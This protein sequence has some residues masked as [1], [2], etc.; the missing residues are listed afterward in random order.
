MYLNCMYAYSQKWFRNIFLKYAISH[1]LQ[2][3]K[4]ILIMM[5]EVFRVIS[6]K[7]FLRQKS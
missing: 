1:D 2:F 4:K 6:I 5:I 7:D 3:H